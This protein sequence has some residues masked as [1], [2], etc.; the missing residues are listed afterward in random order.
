LS[1]A[2]ELEGLLGRDAVS[3]EESD[4]RAHAV[5]WSAGALLRARRGDPPGFPRCVVRPADEEAVDAILRWANEAG[6]PVVPF[7]GGSGVCGGIEARE[8]VVIDLE[9]MNALID[10]DERSRTARVQAGMNGGE[11]QRSLNATGLMLGHQPQSIDISTVGGWVATRACGQLSA[12]Y[13]GIEDAVVGLRASFPN[14]R[15][16]HSTSSPR[17]SRGPEFSSLMIGSEGTLGIVTE[18]TLRVHPVPVERSG[19]VLRFERMADGV[20]ACRKLTQS[21]LHPA[22]V[23]LYDREDAALFLRNHPDEEVAPLLILSFDGEQAGHRAERAVQITGGRRGDGA[24]VEHWW[25]HRN[26]A[27][28][29]YRRLMAGEGLLGPH[30]IVDTMEVSGSWSALRELY[31]SMKESLSVEADLCACHLSHV[32]PDGACL[33]FTLASAESDDDAAL[34]RHERWWETGMEACRRAGGSISHHHGIG[35]LKA[36]WLEAELG[37]WHDALRAIKRSLD[38]NNIMNPGVLGL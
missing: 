29:E 21:T 25:S 36:R 24:L 8:M 35:R 1:A 7:G 5:D 19:V 17:S 27:V 32:Y 26:N 20:A 9:R 4:L 2:D 38:P 30:A 11:L 34:R 14:G 12:G 6:T 33:Y 31:H 3:T 10:V 18:A 22:V 23:R 37:G 28:D 13:G 16:V 15:T